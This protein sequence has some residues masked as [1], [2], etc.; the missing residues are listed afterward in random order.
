MSKISSINDS[1]DNSDEILK[2][3]LHFSEQ[4]INS[5]KI[6]DKVEFVPNVM[7]KCGYNSCSILGNNKLFKSFINSKNNKDKEFSL[8]CFINTFNKSYSNEST[9]KNN[10]IIDLPKISKKL[11]SN[12]HIRYKSSNDLDI[13]TFQKKNFH[14]AKCGGEIV[15]NFFTNIYS[16]EISNYTISPKKNKKGKPFCN[17]GNKINNC[18][19][20]AF[21]NEN[22]KFE[23]LFSNKLSCNNLNVG[24]NFDIKE[25]NEINNLQ[26]ENNICTSSL[27]S[28]DIKNGK[29]N[30][31]KEEKKNNL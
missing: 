1:L 8:L 17:S 7:I 15:N 9:D 18:P 14:L 23:R 20:S 29:C 3:F 31:K 25:Q 26:K 4:K 6:K 28:K 11:F 30:E 24:F 10:I 5:T 19:I 22:N 21:S 13:Y 2:K 27:L 16:G 12:S